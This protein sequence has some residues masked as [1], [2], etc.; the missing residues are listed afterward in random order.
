MPGWLE[1]GGSKLAC[2]NWQPPWSNC[3]SFL[4][5]STEVLALTL[6]FVPEHELSAVAEQFEVWV[7]EKV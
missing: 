6:M 5:G 2:P 7:T 4:A 3:A 1:H